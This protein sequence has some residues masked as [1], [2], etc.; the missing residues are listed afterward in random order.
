MIKLTLAEA[1]ALQQAC[2]GDLR[3]QAAVDALERLAKARAASNVG[4]AK[5]QAPIVDSRGAGAA[6]T[7]AFAEK[8]KW[9]DP[10][11][12]DARVPVAWSAV[13]ELVSTWPLPDAY[14]SKTEGRFV[15]ELVRP[16]LASG[17]IR[18]WG[19]EPIRLRIAPGLH[20]TPDVVAVLLDGELEL[21][22]AKGGY[23][24]SQDRVRIKA[25]AG[26]WPELHIRIW[27]WKGGN[28]SMERVG[29]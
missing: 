7:Q 20:Y 10:L 28:W 15:Q 11:V 18:A 21:W 8:R 3:S 17:E 27:Q 22:E 13:T 24:W 6:A 26:A 5:G 12:L 23:Q 4:V 1:R 2:A 19:Y 25:A 16:A 9:A 29:W 14:R